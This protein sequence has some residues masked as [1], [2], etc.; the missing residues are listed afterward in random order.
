VIADSSYKIR[1][2]PRPASSE[3]NETRVGLYRANDSA[4][5]FAE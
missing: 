3:F 5:P 4:T 1:A 2:W